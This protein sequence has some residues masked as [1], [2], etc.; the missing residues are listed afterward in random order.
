MSTRPDNAAE[1][2]P[3]NFVSLGCPK[4]LVDSETMLGLLDK[5]DFAIVRPDD[6]ARVTVINTCGFVEE[7]KQE[8][9]DAILE[10]AEKKKAGGLDLIVVTGCLSQRYKEELPKLIPEV[11][12]FVGTG[13]YDRL[14]GLIRH[15][16][17]GKEG[18]SY[19]ENPRFLPDHLTPRLQTTPFYTK[20]VK[21]SEGCSHRC[22]FC[23]IPFMRGDL[24]SR[25]QQDIVAEIR[26]GVTAGVKEFNLVGQDL[27]EYGRDLAER[28]SLYKFLKDLES[29]DG[30]Y[31]LRLMYTY[32]LQFPDKLVELIASHPHVAKYVDI[33]LQHISDRMLKKMN[34]G[35]SSKYVY[36]L[37]DQLKK[38]VPG[39]VLRT[40]FIVG[41]PGETDADFE[42]LRTFIGDAEFDRVG[43]F[44][45][46]PEEGT[47]SFTMS[48]PVEEK[49]K[50]ARLAELMRLQQKISLKKNKAL[51]GKTLKALY[52]GPSEQSEYLGTARFEGMA[53]DIDGEILIRDG[54]AKP[55]EFCRVKIV[56]AFEYDLLGEVV[57]P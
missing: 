45:F 16:L 35:S 14:P 44:K 20:Y 25:Q 6:Q 38:K 5:D 47:P 50:S 1:K 42:E 11:D 13:E 41:H 21:I 51:V 15:K 57:T 3:V 55:G 33:P 22:S 56:D 54:N 30:D 32:P 4:N 17:S 37:I 7:S 24:H 27:N 12:L 10:V 53:P 18:K 8:S 2:V 40:T 31:W 48:G 23:I 39:I 29:V 26:A 43:V 52:E 36:R 46:S 9:I 34:R 49:I 19:V 28:P